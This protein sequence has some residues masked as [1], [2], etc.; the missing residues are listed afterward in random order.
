[1]LFLFRKTYGYRKSGDRVSFA[2]LERGTISSNGTIID[3]GTGLSRA[4]IWRALKGLQAKGLIEVHRQTTPLGDLDINYYRIRE[5]QADSP[6]GDPPDLPA[7]SPSQA[8]PRIRAPRGADLGAGVKGSGSRRTGSFRNETTPVSELDHP[9]FETEPPGG[10]GSKPT[11][12]DSTRENST[13]TPDLSALAL[14]FL[15]S[16]GY[17]RPA[18]TKR[19]RTLQVLSRLAEDDGFSLEE[20]AAA[21]KIAASM[22]AR[23]PELIPHVIGRTA[24]KPPDEGAQHGLA[25]R[26]ARERRRWQ[27]LTA[28]FEKLSEAER[29][30]L[31]AEARTS[32]EVLAKRP[33]DHPLVR[34]AAIALLEERESA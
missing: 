32:S 29:K 20:L 26:E 3:R 19:E 6:A 13:L 12:T 14:R 2:Q 25:E 28:R 11:R 34:G 9:G 7:T 15:Q 1:M 5:D 27:A 21:C 8:P 17:A 23:G 22:G 18:Q 33:V 4:T 24:G 30:G 10:F 31:L 16:I